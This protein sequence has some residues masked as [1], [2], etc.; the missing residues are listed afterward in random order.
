MIVFWKLAGLGMSLLVFGLV[1][2]GCGKTS[3]EHSTSPATAGSGPSAL[4]SGPAEPGADCTSVAHLDTELARNA[5]M[6]L[7]LSATETL[8][9]AHLLELTSLT[10]RQLGVPPVLS[11]E[12]LQCAKNL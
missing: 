4:D 3:D 11:L 2:A 7:S 1:F 9:P 10:A 6:Q 8:T 5:R 12:G